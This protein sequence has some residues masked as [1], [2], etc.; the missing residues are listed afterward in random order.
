MGLGARRCVFQQGKA[1]PT[2]AQT[3]GS[4]NPGF[5]SWVNSITCPA[6]T[7]CVLSGKYITKCVPYNTAACDI[8]DQN[9]AKITGQK[10]AADGKCYY[11]A[12]QQ[13]CGPFSTY[14]VG[15]ANKPFYQCFRNVLKSLLV[16]PDGTDCDYLNTVKTCANGQ[17][18]DDKTGTCD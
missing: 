15:N 16:T 13:A 18:C 11:A 1:L 4:V 14:C 17:K 7:Y 2:V 10:C 6:G 5:L 8:R 12:R 9:G 3:C